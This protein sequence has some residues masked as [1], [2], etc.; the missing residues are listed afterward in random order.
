MNNSANHT[1]QIFTFRAIDEPILCAKYSQRHLEALIAYGITNVASNNES[2]T[3]HPYIYCTAIKNLNTN[4][5]VGGVRLQLSDGINP[6]PLETGVGY[7]DPVLHEK[8]RNHALTG[9][10]AE[11]C[12]LWVNDNLKGMG[13][14]RLLMRASISTAT[15][16]DL[17]KIFGVCG[18]HTLKLFG[19]M[20]FV[21]DRSL[22]ENGD[23]VYPT[24][25]H[26]ANVIDI[27]NPTALQNASDDERAIIS[28]LRANKV[29]TRT[30]KNGIEVH[31]DL[32]YPAISDGPDLNA[33]NYDLSSIKAL[34]SN[35]KGA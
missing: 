30:E 34:S 5:L 9:R 7:L 6:L 11:S 21:I 16:L 18:W 27:S 22:G 12:G 35:S 3:N 32:H 26:I 1:F 13:I 4:E 14:S 24:P 23:F 10:V 29:Q 25:N 17:R 15:Q 33:N 28:S 20:G 8:I 31:Y 19:E 2:W